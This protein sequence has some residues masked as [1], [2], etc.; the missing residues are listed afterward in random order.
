[1]TAASLVD[2]VVVFRLDG[3]RLGCALRRVREVV[4]GRALTALPAAGAPL[5]GLL[6]IRGRPLPVYDV[7]AAA[8]LGGGD[9]LVLG[10]VRRRGRVLPAVGLR[11]D[12]VL[13][14]LDGVSLPPLL[15]AP[16]LDEAL[17]RHVEGVLA[18]PE[19]LLPV[20]DPRA[21]LA[22]LTPGGRPEPDQT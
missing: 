22:R 12:E 18:L 17:P 6:E 20:V 7:G 13:G 10:A 4:R 3:Q 14:V 15:P 1:V 9:V 21:L 11:V 16:A 2:G 19:G 5:S 8:P